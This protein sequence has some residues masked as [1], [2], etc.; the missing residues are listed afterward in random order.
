LNNW[1]R[2]LE[3]WSSE[4][5]AVVYYGNQSEREEQRVELLQMDPKANVIVTTYN[6]CFQKP[7]AHFLKKFKFTYLILGNHSQHACNSIATFR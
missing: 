1:E 2:E 5:N 4:L 3:E 6:I 7:D